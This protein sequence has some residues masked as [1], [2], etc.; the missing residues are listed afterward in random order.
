MTA[1]EG[2]LAA[3]GLVCLLLAGCNAPKVTADLPKSMVVLMPSEDGT[4][5]KVTVTSSGETKQLDKAYDG[6]QLGGHGTPFKVDQSDVNRIF[7]SA[8]EILPEAEASF[9]LYF[10]TNS[11]SMDQESQKL[12][13]EIFR[14]V[15]KYKSTDVSVIGHTDSTGTSEFNAVLGLNRAKAVAEIL[16]SMGIDMANIS[17]VSH[18]DGNPLVPTPRGVAEP[19]NRRVEIIIR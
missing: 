8:L 5:G 14:A 15:S 6:L 12:L 16:N 11:T 10:L 1:R 18:G 17:I 3:A 2:S 4:V 9:T 13:P 7:G 19:K